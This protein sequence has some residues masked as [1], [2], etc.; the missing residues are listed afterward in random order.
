MAKMSLDILYS[1]NENATLERGK[2]YSQ[3]KIQVKVW[4][5]SIYNETIYKLTHNVYNGGSFAT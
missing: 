1:G 5:S 2:L 4:D 3:C